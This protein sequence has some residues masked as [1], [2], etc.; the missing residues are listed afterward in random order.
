MLVGSLKTEY[1][2]RPLGTDADRPRFSW[3]A[4]APGYGARQT[5]YQVQLTSGDTEVWDSGKVPSAQSFGIEY[6]GPP[7]TPRTRYH[8][9]V[10]LWDADDR[11]TPTASDWFETALRNEG[12]ANAQWIGG[13]TDTAP[14]LRRAFTVDGDIQRARLYASGL[15][16]ADLR[17]NG[18]PVTDAVLDPGFTDYGRT[19]LYVTHDVT[20][21]LQPGDNAVGAELGR[22]FFAMNTPNVWR[23]HQAPWTSEPRLLARLVIEYA[24]GRVTEVGTDDQWR[25]IGGPTVSDSLYTGETYDARR[26]LPGWDTAAFD[27]SAWS[28]ATLVDAPA[29][30]LRAQEHEPIRVV[31]TV[32][33]VAVDEVRPGVWIADFG[34]TTAGWARLRVTAGA[35]TTITLTYGETVANGNVIAVNGHVDGDRIQR[36]EYIAAGSGVEEWEPRF[37]YKGFR[38]VQIEGARPDVELRVVNS[39]VAS[40]TAFTSSE[41]AYEQF[42][43]AM[44]RTVLSNLHGIP[45]DTPF[46][47]KNGWTGDAQVGAPTMLATLDLAR[48]FGK[49]LGDIRD[50]QADSGQLPVI[51]PTSGWGFEELS[52]ATEWPTV[53]PILLHELHRAY[54]D[55]RL[56]REHWDSLTRYLNWELDRVEDGLSISVLG[57]WL[58]PGYS[59]GPALRTG[60]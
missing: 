30:R 22:G 26:A 41:P 59:D 8:W 7:L 25:V 31:E 57:D 53:Y 1:A 36:D 50:S 34:R 42:E 29:G 5:A 6:D 35:G 45:T 32:P 60:G 38:Y 24:D 27:D 4:T 43:Q 20:D 14:L 21:L 51:V 52:P 18:Q 55:E 58:P 17:L 3:V 28:S 15:G 37:S 33:P 44:R 11:E 9:T 56:V 40:V 13:T 2:V 47:E 23:W 16:Y 39:D 48:L 46:Y 49:W 12:F 54:G 19:V 10:R